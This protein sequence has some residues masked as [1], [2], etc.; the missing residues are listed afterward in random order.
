M[1]FYTGGDLSSS[2]YEPLGAQQIIFP[3]LETITNLANNA[4]KKRKG[5]MKIDVPPSV[6]FNSPPSVDGDE[7]D[8]N[9]HE[10]GP[11]QKRKPG[12]KL[13]QTVPTNKRTAQNRAAQRAFRERK[14]RYLKDL[15]AKAEE[16]ETLR[17]AMASGVAPTVTTD[18]DAGPNQDA[19]MAENQNLR[20]RVA[21]LENETRFSGR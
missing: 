4:S 6:D 11:P 3:D 10:D 15:E 1:Q 8:E 18:A 13:A 19:L 7:Y 14:E 2:L 21:E 17:K 5:G 12:R 9:D 20:E 16:L